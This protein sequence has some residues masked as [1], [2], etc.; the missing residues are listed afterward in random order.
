MKN[1]RLFFA[2]VIAFAFISTLGVAKAVAQSG[3]Y[4]EG[5]DIERWI[6]E[7]ARRARIGRREKVRLPLVRRSDGWGCVCPE[8]YVGLNTANAGGGMWLEPRFARRT[9]RLRK[10]TVVLAEGYFTGRRL[11]RDLRTHRDEP[12]ELI[13]E[14]WEFLVTR[15]QAL[16]ENHVF[17]DEANANNQ[18]I[19]LSR[20]AGT[21]PRRD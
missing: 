9:L 2:P 10:N 20:S 8:Y 7:R 3:P 17:Y 6:T 19:L 4:A 13:Y 21:R 15:V 1:L 11:R 12:E 5:P 18:A 16:P 14:Q